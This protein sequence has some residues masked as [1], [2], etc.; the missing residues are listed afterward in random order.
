MATFDVWWGGLTTLNQ[1][2]FVAAAFFSVFFLWQLIAAIMGIGGH[3]MD[4][5]SHVEATDAHQTPDDA[6]QTIVAF[7]LLSVRS[8]L[9]F[10][11]LFTW[12][13]ALY[14][15][16]HVPITRALVYSILWGTAALIF[17]AFLMFMLRKLTSP[18]AA[19][20]GSSVGTLGT[21]Y[22]DIPAGGAGEIRALCGDTM[23]HF[24]ARLAGG[25]GLKAGAQI[26]VTKVL[27]ANTVEVETVTASK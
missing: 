20:I 24:K 23:T 11:T 3:D 14:L 4:V 19:R 15:G 9:A 2:F 16:Q 13:G 12:S 27:D 17:V 10:F 1:C 5:D 18:G 25:N 8:I 26:R 6:D 21:V 22:L 7:K